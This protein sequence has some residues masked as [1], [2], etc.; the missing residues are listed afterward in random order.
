M[1]Q[2][3]SGFFVEL[4]Q[5]A[6]SGGSTSSPEL[7]IFQQH[8]QPPTLNPT[9][10]SRNTRLLEQG[11]ALILAAHPS[12][13]F[14]SSSGPLP[15]QAQTYPIPLVR[16]FNRSASWLITF[17]VHRR[18]HVWVKRVGLVCKSTYIGSRHSRDR[19]AS[20]TWRRD[21]VQFYD[22]PYIFIT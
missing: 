21:T 6:W 10:V 2:I 7:G 14:R 19:F 8:L 20:A 9:N 1:L 4:K 3:Q 17:V 12:M 15:Q 11:L 18:N 16:I 5:E 13:M 22:C